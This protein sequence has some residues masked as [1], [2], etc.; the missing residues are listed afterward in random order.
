MSKRAYET[1]SRNVFKDLGVPN[2]DEHLVKAQ[3]VFKIDTEG[4]EAQVLRGMVG[5]L[6]QVPWSF[7][8]IE[9]YADHLERAGTS[10]EELLG[11]LVERFIVAPL[12]ELAK[13][14]G[15][16]DPNDP[17]NSL[18]SLVAPVNGIVQDLLLVSDEATLA[19]AGFAST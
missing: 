9:F 4:W 16:V 11:W 19:S 12:D 15:R 8:M 17:W 6:E 2:A 14:V 3:L 10:A 1:G 7:G 18:Q 5:L 13:P